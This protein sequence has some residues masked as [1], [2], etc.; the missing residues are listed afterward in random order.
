MYWLTD[1]PFNSF[2]PGYSNSNEKLPSESV[3][4]MV[5]GISKNPLSSV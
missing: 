2:E 1:E 5:N 4:F 3:L